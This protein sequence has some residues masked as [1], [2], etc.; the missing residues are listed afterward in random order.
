[1]TERSPAYLPTTR[2]TSFEELILASASPRRRELLA[3]LGLPFRC[4]TANVDETPIPD[5]PPEALALRLSLA[6]ARAIASAFSQATIIGADTIVVLDGRILGK[7][8]TPEEATAML[9]AL[10]GRMHEVLSA[11]TI[12]RKGRP[13]L[14]ALTRSRIWMRAYSDAEIAA[15]VASGDPMDK[16]GAYAIQHPQFRPAERWEGCYASIMGLPLAE[17]AALLRKAGWTIP[18][19]IAPACRRVIQAPCCQEQSGSG[20]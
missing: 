19:P 6:K 16:A 3:A 11:V 17:V 9:K 12:Y 8:A 4:I 2:S 14:Q 1:M 10:R 13:P 7:P 20:G 5:E 15:Y 18:H